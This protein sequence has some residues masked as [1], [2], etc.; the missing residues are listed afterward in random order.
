MESGGIPANS[1]DDRC[2]EGA[3]QKRQGSTPGFP[4]LPG[5]LGPVRTCVES[6]GNTLAASSSIQRAV[7]SHGCD[8]KTATQVG[9][10][11][12]VRSFAPHSTRLK[13][14]T[15]AYFNQLPSRIAP[16]RPHSFTASSQ[17]VGA[18][19][20]VN[21]GDEC[22]PVLSI[23]SGRDFREQLLVEVERFDDGVDVRQC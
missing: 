15:K 6:S 7:R 22:A 16:F 19:R 2:R 21:E 18:L 5:Q 9:V 17:A 11:R 12:A 10:L 1:R 20:L 14:A 23:P 13:F 4:A 8:P 3:T